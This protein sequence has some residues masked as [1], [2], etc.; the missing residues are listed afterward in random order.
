MKF[1][2]TVPRFPCKNRYEKDTIALGNTFH[3]ALRN[4]LIKIQMAKLQYKPQVIAVTEI[5]K[6]VLRHY[7]IKRIR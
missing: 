5:K 2:Y 1:L 7:R 3:N 6:E 4:E